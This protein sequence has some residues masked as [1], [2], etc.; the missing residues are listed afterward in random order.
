MKKMSKKVVILLATVSMLLVGGLSVD[1]KEKDSKKE[2]K[3]I[4]VVAKKGDT[5]WGIGEK[6]K[7]NMFDLLAFNEKDENDVLHVGEKITIPTK[8]DKIPTYQ[9]KQV[10]PA[11]VVTASEEQSVQTEVEV[12]QTEVVQESQ[13]ETVFAQEK[14]EVQAV[15]SQPSQGGRTFTVQ[16][17]AYDGVSLG[18]VTAT[19]NIITSTGHKVI[20]V[21]PSVIPL[22]S[23]VY[24]EGYGEAIAWDTGGAIQGN[25]IDLNM[26]TGDAIQW[27]RR[28]VTITVY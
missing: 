28:N 4:E 13:T 18:G 19:G 20:A 25:I 12:A 26:S 22:G 7:I 3:R 11:K 8:K 27:G 15:E 17:T 2:V 23:R 16:A 10:A 14:Q 21:D 5:V 6:H 24:V 9:A 1:A